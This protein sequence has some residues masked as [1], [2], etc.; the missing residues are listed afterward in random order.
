[1]SDKELIIKSLQKVERRMRTNRLLR[2][3][4]FGLCISLLI[5]VL[6]KV[7]DIFRPFGGRTVAIVLV[8][9]VIGVAAYVGWKMS[10]KAT[11]LEAA[12][13]IDTRASLRDEIK[14]AYWF[15]TAA[16]TPQRSTEWVELQVRRA[17]RRASQLNIEQLYPRTIPRNSYFAAGLAL[18]LIA[19]NFAPFSQNHNWVLLQ[20]APAFS[21]TPLEL[22]LINETKK[23]LK[24]AQKLDQPELV[25]Q[26]EE[27]VENLQAG[28]IDPAE[29]LKQ[30]DD[31]RNQLAEGNLDMANINEGLD[32]MAKDLSGAPETKDVSEAMAEH[33]LK[34]TAEELKKLAEEAMDAKDAR[35]MKALQDA[36]NQAAESAKPGMQNLSKDMKAAADSLA[37]QDSK[38]F[39]DAMKQAANDVQSLQQKMADQQAKNA[40]SQ[41]IQNLAD[42]LRQRQQE[43]QAKAAQNAGQQGA[44]QQA[45]QGNQQGKEGQPNPDGQGDP[46]SGAQSGSARNDSSGGSQEG[47]QGQ[48]GKAGDQ[49]QAGAAGSGQNPS[50]APQAPM[51]IMGAP[52]KLNVKLEQE[53]LAGENDGGTPQNLEEASKQ[54]RSK[55]D[56]RNIP[57][58]LS[59]AQKDVLNQDKI[60][61]EYKSLI[62]N[63]FQA[64]R[65]PR[66]K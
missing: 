32:E 41:D 59:P 56:Y 14:S 51:N 6:F 10:Q 5:P 52:T 57:S 15:V 50:G 23:L 37:N 66:G 61:W 11:L 24:E 63:Y 29:A 44:A 17:A 54:E 55:L 64:I 20:A 40:A 21:L 62:K 36:L 35:G 38:A 48:P 43:Q 26:L 8:L 65:P 27:I 28:N 13:A 3:V 9:W 31:L 12:A 22:K 34:S 7:W 58:Q 19:L 49:A 18:L 25:K 4:A 46:N 42:S 39:Q 53:K 30:L 45:Q 1:M 16:N 47:Q 2:E 33:D 60:P